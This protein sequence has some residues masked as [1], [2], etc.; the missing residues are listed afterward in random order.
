[1]AVH[2]E[3]AAVTRALLALLNAIIEID[4]ALLKLTPSQSQEF[5]GHL[6]ASHDARSE[7]YEQVKRLVDLME[8]ER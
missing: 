4:E 7:C 6:R 3:T 1:M 8:K 2:A 5:L